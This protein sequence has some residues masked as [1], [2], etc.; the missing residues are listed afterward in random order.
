MSGS[1]RTVLWFWEEYFFILIVILGGWNNAEIG[2]ALR[3]VLSLS[4][5]I[6]PVGEWFVFRLHNGAFEFQAWST[7]ALL[8]T[9][10]AGPIWSH[11]LH[12]SRYYACL[13]GTTQCNQRWCKSNLFQMTCVKFVLSWILRAR[14]LIE[15]DSSFWSLWRRL[16]PRW[17][18]RWEA[19][20]LCWSKCRTSSS[21]LSQL[22]L[23]LCRQWL[24]AVLRR[25]WMAPPHPSPR[26]WLRFADSVAW[27]AL[28]EKIG[29]PSLCFLL[30]SWNNA[31][32]EKCCSWNNAAAEAISCASV[33]QSINPL[34]C[35]FSCSIF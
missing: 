19:L 3:I 33:N 7:V 21:Q 10:K 11:H 24:G 25:P 5:H 30:C 18:R 28:D 6:S 4:V 16:T 34:S 23:R 26:L 17:R 29:Q 22:R 2:R 35:S 20:Q 1:L 32:G 27:Q 31:A 8:P 15:R 13:E 12:C 14:L 9:L